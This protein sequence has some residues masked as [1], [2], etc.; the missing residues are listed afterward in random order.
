MFL[1]EFRLVTSEFTSSL[2]QSEFS[3]LIYI[4]DVC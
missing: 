1:N 4:I 2:Q 3:C